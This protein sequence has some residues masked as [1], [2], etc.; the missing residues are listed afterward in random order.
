ML[1]SLPPTAVNDNAL[2]VPFMIDKEVMAEIFGFNNV[3]D[4]GALYG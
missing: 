1:K 2:S 3:Y 4:P